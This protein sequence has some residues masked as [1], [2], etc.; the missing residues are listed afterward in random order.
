MLPASPIINLTV[1][2]RR[3]A[4]ADERQRRQGG[5]GA[6]RN[7]STCTFW[8]QG[9][10]LR[11]PPSEHSCPIAP[12]SGGMCGE[13]AQQAQR[14][15]G[16]Q[17]AGWIAFRDCLAQFQTRPNL[18]PLHAQPSTGS[19]VPRQLFHGARP[20]VHASCTPS[21]TPSDQAQQISRQVHRR[22][23]LDPPVAAAGGGSGGTMADLQ[24][25]H[26]QAKKLILTIRA[27]L[28]RL[29]TAEQVRWSC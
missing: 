6:A 22:N 28:E 27:G 8:G 24:Q 13:Q 25:L 3:C 19:S 15:H 14:G 1:L 20:A 17:E 29:E 16:A 23:R 11:E 9:A 4:R 18:I 21:R 2:T 5:L 12:L 10:L 26:T 7:P